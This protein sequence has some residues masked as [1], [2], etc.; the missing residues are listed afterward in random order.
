[1]GNTRRGLEKAR[2]RGPWGL[3]LR[4]GPSL[5]SA[6]PRLRSDVTDPRLWS[7]PLSAGNAPEVNSVLGGAW[8]R[9]GMRAEPGLRR[10]GWR[11]AE[12]TPRPVSP[13]FLQDTLDALFN[14]MMENSES[15]TFDTLV[16]DALVRGPCSP[17]LRREEARPC[18]SL[19]SRGRGT[20][21]GDLERV[22]LCIQSR[23]IG[24]S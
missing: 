9:G 3:P 22:A 12:L 14:I 16:F 7:W 15:E 6:H 10:P 11:G 19:G 24:E 18:R 1:M 13:Q 2:G 5:H 20:P 21:R 17:P 8:P 23:P 4:P